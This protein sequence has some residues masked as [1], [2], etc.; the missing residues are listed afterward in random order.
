MPSAQ[1]Y[2][3]RH[4]KDRGGSATRQRITA[5]VREL[6]DEGTF[7]DATVEEVA[8][9]AGVSRATL[10]QHFGSRLE[11]VDAICDTFAA[12]PALLAV[13]ESVVKPDAEAALAETIANCVSFWSAEE[14]VLTQLYGVAAIDPAA[15]DLV[16]RQ[17]DDRRGE[18]RRLVRGLRDSG[19][20]RA[21]LD[22]RRALAVLLMLTSFETFEELRRHAGLSLDA[23]RETLQEEAAP[24]L[25]QPEGRA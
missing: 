14:A 7:H 1:A 20:L 11:L 15:A 22:E 3:R 16:R 18:L 4:R 8:K 5:A 2:R 24:L 12:N 13:R 6:L 23:V 17:R 21:D 9:R 10:Y 25:L 19:R